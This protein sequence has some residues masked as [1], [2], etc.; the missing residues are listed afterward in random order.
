M[1]PARFAVQAILVLCLILLVSWPDHRLGAR[2]ASWWTKGVESDALSDL[3]RV[4]RGARYEIGWGQAALQRAASKR[5]HGM[6]AAAFESGHSGRRYVTP[7]A[8]VALGGRVNAILGD[9]RTLQDVPLGRAR[10]VLRDVRTGLVEAWATAD[11]SGRFAFVDVMPSG[12]VVELIGSD[13]MVAATSEFISVGAGDLRQ[14][15]VR[16]AGRTGLAP[17]GALGATAPA[18]TAAAAAGGARAVAEPART[19]SPQ[20]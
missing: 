1:S 17:F 13:G 19:I 7:A 8:V 15:Q 10:L 14:T 20:R 5:S 11:D 6:R 9:V 4:S 3:D 12:Y 2:D 16:L 18:Q